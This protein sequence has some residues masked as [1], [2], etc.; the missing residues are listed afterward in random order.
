MTDRTILVSVMAA[1]N[2]IG[3]LQPIRAIGALCK[4]RGV[5]FHSDAVQS[6][7]KV[8]LDVNDVG[9]DLLSISAHKLYGPKGTGAL[10]VRSREPRVRLEPIID[11]GG[12]ERGMRSGTLAVPIIVGFGAA[13]E[14]CRQEMAGEADRLRRLRDHL[15]HG[16][17]EGLSDLRLNGHPTER[18]PGNLNLSFAHVHGE[19]LLARIRDVALSSGSACTTAEPEP[20]YVLRAIGLDDELAH[21]SLRFGLGRFNTEE[22]VDYVIESVKGAVKEL[23]AMSPMYEMAQRS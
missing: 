1:N 3:T 2:E 19:A 11:G 15:E 13:S 5:L 9:V 10:Y 16:L 14:L 8:P 4:K 21:S 6:V 12:H 22:E 18:L 20:S 23:R 17:M 7:G